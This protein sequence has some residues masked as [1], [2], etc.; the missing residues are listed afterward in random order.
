MK[1][2]V[3][4]LDRGKETDKKGKDIAALSAT[5]RW[6]YLKDLTTRAQKALWFMKAYGLEVEEN[7]NT[8]HNLN[9]TDTPTT[10]NPA[11]PA[12]NNEGCTYLSLQEDERKKVEEVLF[13][14]DR[15]SVSKEFYR[16]LTMIFNGLPRSYF[17]QAM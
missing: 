3:E 11:V 12:T 2:Y 6:S 7:N 9:L 10:S 15:F 16:H 8:K 13:L 1:K 14:M 5:L 4:K 17:S